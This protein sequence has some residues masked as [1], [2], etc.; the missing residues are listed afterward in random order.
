VFAA[1]IAEI[2]KTATDYPPLAAEDKKRI[3][4]YMCQFNFDD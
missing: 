3:E 4:N 1:R 2:L